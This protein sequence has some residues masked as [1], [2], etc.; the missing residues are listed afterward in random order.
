MEEASLSVLARPRARPYG[1]AVQG[2][3]L[4]REMHIRGLTGSALAR[5]AGVAPSTVSQAL[6]DHRVHPRKLQA[7]VQAL[8][9]VEP[10]PELVKLLEDNSSAEEHDRG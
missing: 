7:I 2:D 4:R 10:I 6:N 9:G 8:A 3:R 5:R 1:V